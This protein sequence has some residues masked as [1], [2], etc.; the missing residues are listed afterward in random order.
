[1]KRDQNKTLIQY[2]KLSKW[3]DLMYAA[4]GTKTGAYQTELTEKLIGFCQ[5]RGIKD[6][7]DCAC[8]TGDPIIGLAKHGENLNCVGS[9]GCE[10]MLK[11]CVLNSTD[12]GL[13]ILPLDQFNPDGNNPRSLFVG[14]VEWDKL[15]L[16]FKKPAFD[17]VMCRGNAI[18]HLCTQEDTVNF[19]RS[20]TSLVKTGGYVMVD[21][22]LWDDDLKGEKGRD[23]V[24]FR[25]WVPSNE[26]ANDTGKRLLL[27]D[28]CDYWEDKTA[29]SGVIQRKTLHVGTFDDGK[30]QIIDSVFVVGAPYTNRTLME[31]MKEAG[32]NSLELV[33]LP[34]VRYPAVIG[35][36]P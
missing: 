2:S 1:M 16:A 17:M 6:I 11:R 8:G 27:M 4:M 12:S 13:T 36:K 9:D 31:M 10:E 19:I 35:R 5:E 30:L 22:L 7:W 14:Q 15:Q 29:V 25:G 32:L 23:V 20:M 34:G 21:T 28:S 18:Y 33:E 24:K 26:P 3:Y